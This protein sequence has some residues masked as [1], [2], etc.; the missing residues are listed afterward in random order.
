M[1]TINQ[2]V[3]LG[4]E[5]K[6][7]KS[8]SK[9][10]SACHNHKLLIFFNRLPQTRK[11]RKRSYESYRSVIVLSTHFQ[12]TATGCAGSKKTNPAKNLAK[13]T[14]FCYDYFIILL[15]HQKGN[16]HETCEKS[17]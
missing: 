13:T 16:S 15:A 17:F 1:P 2:L 4:R 6:E 14:G 7:K 12:L 9:A 11:S 3:R 8:K 10:L 5:E